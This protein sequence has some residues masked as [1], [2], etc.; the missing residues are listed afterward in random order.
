MIIGN[1]VT[2]IHYGAFSKCPLN[3]FYSYTQ[4]PPI[5]DFIPEGMNTSNMPTE[6]RHSFGGVNKNN[7]TLYVPAGCKTAYE[8]S[9]W[10]KYFGTIVEMN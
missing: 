9:D 5:L 6:V 2:T 7:A 1:K 8:V 10:A 4:T 3:A